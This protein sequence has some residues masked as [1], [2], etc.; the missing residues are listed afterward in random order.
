MHTYHW[1]LIIPGAVLIAVGIVILL[2][3]WFPRI[4]GHHK[5]SKIPAGTFYSVSAALLPCSWGIL[6]IWMGIHSA[7]GEP[8]AILF[9]A[10]FILSL[11]GCFYG[12]SLDIRAHGRK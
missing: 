7:V 3:I 5:G 4:R 1:K 6:L 2:G 12:H 8:S 11:A 10:P 9:I